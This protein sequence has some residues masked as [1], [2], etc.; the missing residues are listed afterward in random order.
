MDYNAR[1]YSPQI[2]QFISADTIVPDP[3]N[4]LSFNRYAYV[5][6]NPILFLDPNGHEKVVI[7]YGVDVY[8][9]SFLAAAETQYRY[10]LEQGYTEEEILMVQ[11]STGDEF[12]EAIAQNDIGEI[13]QVHVFL[14]GWGIDYDGTPAGGLTLNKSPEADAVFEDYDEYEKY[15]L[16]EEDL[17]NN[18][19]NRFADNAYIN[20]NAC[21][22]AQGTFPQEVSNTFDAT[23]R[24]FNTPTKFFY[25]SSP[26]YNYPSLLLPYNGGNLETGVNENAYKGNGDVI[27]LPVKMSIIY[28]PFALNEYDPQ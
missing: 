15:D 22:T 1:Y 7:I 21:L 17:P 14:H 11:V 23:V 5:D 4:V 25:F 26:N 8:T 9:N 16:T 12:L 2:Q 27:P 20:I 10:A 28:W 18:L 13:E 24:A 6:N 3:M 19:D